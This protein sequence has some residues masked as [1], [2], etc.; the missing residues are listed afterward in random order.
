M[1]LVES[2]NNLL[3]MLHDRYGSDEHIV[4]LLFADPMNEDE[5]GRYITNRFDYLH[6]R[7][8]KYVDF[9]CVG[10][11]STNKKRKF[12]IKDY[13]EFINQLEEL[14]TWRY[15][16]G[17]N[18]LFLRYSDYNLQFDC[19]YDLNLTRMLIEGLIKDYRYFLEEII[20]NLRQGFDEYLSEKRGE[21]QLRSI[22]NN[23]SEM[24]PNFARGIINQIN[25][26]QKINKYLSPH[27]IRREIFPY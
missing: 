27:D 14:T 18:L 17:T 5:I 7:S 16:G 20:Y 21:T 4:C 11:N 1:L 6:E 10:Y 2:Y 3:N 13:V 22:W 26:S 24:L 23:F 8:G 25:D 15:Y 9:F 19:V 12:K